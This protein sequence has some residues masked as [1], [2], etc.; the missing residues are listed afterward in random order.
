MV[1]VSDVKSARWFC[2]L[3]VLHWIP[4]MHNND[5]QV[6]SSKVM[7]RSRWLMLLTKLKHLHRCNRKTQICNTWFN[8]Q[9]QWFCCKITFVLH[10]DC[11]ICFMKEA[12]IKSCWV[13]ISIQWYKLCLN[14]VVHNPIF[15]SAL[16][17]FESQYKDAV[18]RNIWH[19]FTLLLGFYSSEGQKYNCSGCWTL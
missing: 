15:K 12:G 2:I 1:D 9:S 17:L 14:Q 8:A 5:S 19:A 3:L 11:R 18:E 13:H 6:I 7:Y 16:N 10:S 4:H